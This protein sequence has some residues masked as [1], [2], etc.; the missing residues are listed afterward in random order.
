[1]M[2]VHDL[3]VAFYPVIVRMLLGIAATVL[4]GKTFGGRLGE[5]DSFDSPLIFP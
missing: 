1:M 2:K 5:L 4:K 3:V